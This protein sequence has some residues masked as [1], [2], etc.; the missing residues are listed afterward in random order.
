MSY[1]YIFVPH[2]HPLSLFFTRSFVRSFSFSL[3]R[4]SSETNIIDT[5]AH[6]VN[7]L[8]VQFA[9]A[10]VYL[11]SETRTVVPK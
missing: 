9:Y 2:S 5:R 11:Q 6:I 7:R 4:I 3:A 8:Y 1:I 10:Y